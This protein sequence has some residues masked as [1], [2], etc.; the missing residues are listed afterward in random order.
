MNVLEAILN[1]QNGEAVGQLARNFDLD[2]G[3]AVSAVS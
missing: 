3:Q 2:Q 1:S